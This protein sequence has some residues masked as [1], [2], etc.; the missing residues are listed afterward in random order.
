MN[1]IVNLAKK[2]EQKYANSERKSTIQS[3]QRS[4]RDF[5]FAAWANLTQSKRL[6]A[7]QDCVYFGYKTPFHEVYFDFYNSFFEPVCPKY[8]C[9]AR[10]F[11]DHFLSVQA[12][13]PQRSIS[14]VSR[15]Y[16]RSLCQLRAMKEQRP[17]DVLFFFLDEYKKLGF[18]Y[19]RRQI[20]EP[21]GFED[22]S[23]AEKKA[24][25]GPANAAS[26]KGFQKKDRLSRMQELFLDFYSRPVKLYNALRREYA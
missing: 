21:L 5:M 11:A 14:T 6:K 1:K 13:W 20:L 10:N 7:K 19:L 23:A 9:C 18:S 24:G 22:V 17:E 26:A 16:V 3:W 4:K 2:C 25:K 15:R 8:V 12:R